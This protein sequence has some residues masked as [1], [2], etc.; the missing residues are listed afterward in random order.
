M[1]NRALISAVV[2][3][4]ASTL[5][6]PSFTAKVVGVSDGDTI[7]VYDGREQTRTRL[8]GIDCPE[9]DTDF[10]QRAKQFTS[11]LVFGKQVCI[12]GKESVIV[13]G[14]RDENFI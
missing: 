7:T 1:Q 14:G 9:N 13:K 8:D 3:F 4:A 2:A 10:S 6:V 12:E 5:A 11:G